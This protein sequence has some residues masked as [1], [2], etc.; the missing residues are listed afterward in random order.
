MKLHW[1]SPLSPAATDIAHYTARL[2]P[3]LARRA[4]VVLW[5]EQKKWNKALSR[6]AEVRCY[7]VEQMPFAELN[8]EGGMCIYHI[9][10]NPVFHS[11]IWHL[12]QLHSGIVVLHDVRLHRF[13]DGVYREQRQDLNSYLAEMQFFYDE[14]GRRDAAECFS[15]NA[16]NIEYMVTQ[17]PLTGLAVRDALGVLVHTKEAFLELS[18]GNR[19]PVSYAPLPFAS[20]PSAQ[21]KSARKIAHPITTQ[22]ETPYRLIVFGYIGHN[23]RLEAIFKA[24]AQLPEKDRFLL[25]IYGEMLESERTLAAI[26]Q[27]NL[28][29]YV[30]VH[31]FVSDKE[32]DDAL[33][34]ADLAINLRYPTMGEA[35][36]SQLRLWDH[37][38]PS[39]VTKTGWYA[40][41]PEDAVAFVRTE[42]ET[43][44]ISAH[45][46]ALLLDPARFKAMGERGQQVLEEEHTPENYADA[47][48]DL[49][50]RAEKFRAQAMS[51]RLAERAG[52]LISLWQ[53]WP[54]P[55]EAFRKAATEIQ[56]LLNPAHN[57]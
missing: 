49:A 24:L 50:G 32:L 2:L 28:E 26:Q 51:N 44:D 57:S 46:R 13:F 4:E 29:D 15:T 41:L 7:K 54:P 25:D 56:A 12:S 33:Q 37:A 53:D 5:T 34:R 21:R 45:L 55:Y 40:S 38:L 52:A 18:K 35:S 48:I 31:G 17:Y 11:S 27:L 42:H 47:I 8:R 30:T 36:G 1:F 43:E 9:G 39:L 3:A 19:R 14:A 6:L 23:R 10:N 22:N 20:T 16:C